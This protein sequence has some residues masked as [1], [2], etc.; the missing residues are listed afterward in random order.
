[1]SISDYF[2]KYL[3]KI[4]SETLKMWLVSA[5]I[6]TVLGLI[7]GIVLFLTRKSRS[8]GGKIAYKILDFLVNTLRS[9]PFYIL[10]FFVIPFTRIMMKIFTGK[11]SFASSDA[12]IVPL[13]IAA[14][15]FFG[16][17]FENSLIEVK[18]NVIEAAKSLGLSQWQIIVKVVLREALPSLISGITLGMITLIGYTAMASIVSGGGIGSFAY[19]NGM[20]N[21]DT[22]AMLYAV[23]TIMILVF[24][25]Q[26]LG[27]FIYKKTK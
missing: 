13:V 9:F 22:N 23:F 8:R 24:I 26:F 21:Y 17:I 3:G 11:A 4:L 2:T 27:N 14:T 10:V 25:V 15:P 7:V 5:A 20:Q 6:A 19:T 1:M 12:F 18:D 16:K